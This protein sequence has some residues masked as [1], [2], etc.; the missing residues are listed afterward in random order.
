MRFDQLDKEEYRDILMYRLEEND[1]GDY[2]FYIRRYIL[3]NDLVHTRHRHDYFQI[4]YI[5]RGQLKHR[6]H[7]KEYEMIKGDLF[8]LPPY[9]P[10]SVENYDHVSCEVIELEFKPEFINQS[11]AGDVDIQSFVD[12]MYIEPAMVQE[13]KLR[14]RLS[15][16]GKM[17]G[18]AESILNDILYEFNG[19]KPGFELMAKALMLKLLA[20]V[21]REAAPECHRSDTLVD[22]H[23]ES[24]LRVVKYL[25]EHYAEKIYLEDAVKVSLLSH[26]A[27]C[28]V[29]R[30]VTQKSF[31]RYLNELR[32]SKAKE[33]LKKT[34]IK[35]IDICSKTG[36]DNVT[37][38]NR[39]FKQL[40]SMTPKAYKQV[41]R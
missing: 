20:M 5:T 33:Y 8:V 39:T 32:V 21:G 40:T 23:R 7:D 30:N 25:E 6:I 3:E 27:F 24:V 4:Y 15:L 18:D 34:D 16:A 1:H 28:N 9:V 10:H 17:E 41:N 22:K 26:T 13:S 31:T 29:F 12:F 19:K 2:P 38:F 14:Q 37:H 11:F 35:M 36:F